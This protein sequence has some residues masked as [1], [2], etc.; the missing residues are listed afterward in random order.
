VKHYSNEFDYVGKGI[1][2]EQLALADAPGELPFYVRR[3]VYGVELPLVIGQNSLL[4]R[5]DSNTVYDE[6]KVRAVRL[7]D[8]FSS[9]ASE[10]C[11]VWIDVE[12][13]TGK[14][15][16]GGQRVL[17]QTQLLMIEVEDQPLWQDQL[18]AG[19]ALESLYNLGLVPVARDFEW[20]PDNYNVVCVRNNLLGRG[21]IRLAIA[22]FYSSAG[23]G[24][25]T[26]PQR[27]LMSRLM[28]GLRDPR[29]AFQHLKFLARRE[30]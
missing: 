16:S 29:R 2:Y 11:C 26:Q 18:L 25:R 12:G 17:G 22:R 5:V 8:F 23:Q 1:E 10:D 9:S 30:R 24:V 3:S 15:I 13:Y 27:T 20:W 14:V 19:E 4:K 7:D 28:K 21:D 6:I